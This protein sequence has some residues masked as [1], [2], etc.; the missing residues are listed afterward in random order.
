[1]AK[2][3]GTIVKW[4][5]NDGTVK[6]GFVF[7]KDQNDLLMSSGRVL[8]TKVDENLIALNEPKIMKRAELLTVIG[9]LD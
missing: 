7:N 5:S 8:I 1:M 6:K 2:N 3:R 9:F 4:D